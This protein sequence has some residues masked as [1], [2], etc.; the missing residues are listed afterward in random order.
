MPDSAHEEYNDPVVEEEGF[1][2]AAPSV[3]PTHTVKENGAARTLI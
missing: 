2:G 1:E 3:S